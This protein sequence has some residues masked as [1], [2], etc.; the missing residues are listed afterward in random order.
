MAPHLGCHISVDRVKIDI[1]AKTVTDV[2]LRGGFVV[3]FLKGQ[4][5]NFVKVKG[6]KV[7]LSKEKQTITVLSGGARDR[8]EVNNGRNTPDDNGNGS[9]LHC[10]G[11]P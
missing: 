5:R 9:T 8:I 2:K 10:N 11:V 7:Q 4:T 6:L 1:G 3:F